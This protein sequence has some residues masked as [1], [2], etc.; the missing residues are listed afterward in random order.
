M[1]SNCEVSGWLKSVSCRTY[2]RLYYTYIILCRALSKHNFLKDGEDSPAEDLPTDRR[3][4]QASCWR[5]DESCRWWCVRGDTVWPSCWRAPAGSAAARWC[6][7]CCY[8]WPAS[9]SRSSARSS[10]TRS[11]SRSNTWTHPSSTRRQQQHDAVPTSHTALTLPSNRHHRSNGDCLEG[12]RENYQ[13][14]SVQYCAQQL[15]TVQC[16]HIWTDLTVV[17]IGFCLTGPI[18]LC[19]DSFLYMYY[20]MHA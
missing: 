18:S 3:R 15:Y 9:Q 6:A 1:H 17:W 4:Q 20:C 11:V 12:K 13:V 2:T 19:L 5:G 8:T 7:R 10:C 16:T 14:C